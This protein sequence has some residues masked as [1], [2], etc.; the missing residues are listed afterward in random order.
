MARLFPLSLDGGLGVCD[1]FKLARSQRRFRN[2]LIPDALLLEVRIC[3]SSSSFTPGSRTDHFAA[4][5]RAIHQEHRQTVPVDKIHHPL[6][7]TAIPSIKK[8]PKK[9]PKS[10]AKA[11]KLTHHPRHLK[12]PKPPR[13]P[14][15]PKV[16]IAPTGPQTV[17]VTP[18]ATS[19][20]NSFAAAVK[21]ATPGETIV[22]APGTYTQNI[23]VSN[24][25]NITI[26]GAA[27]QSSILAPASGDAIKVV[28]SS[29][30]TIENVWF[31]SQGSQGRGLA[32]VGSS[33]NVQSIKTDGTL[34]DGVVTTGYEGRSA[35][36]NATS[37]QFDAVQTGDGLDL[38]NGSSAIIN[39]STFNG[40][41]TAPGVSQASN[42]L[43][44]SGNATANISNSQFIG[45]TNTGLGAL[46][47][48]QVT[49]QGCTFSS[50]KLGDGAIFFD[51]S[52]AN[53]TGNTF[54]SNGEVF[55]PTTGLNGLEFNGNFTGNA[56]VSGNV[57][58]GNTGDGIF[59]GSAP[60]TIQ[61]TNNV[62]NDNFAGIALYSDGTSIHVNIQSNTLEIPATTPTPF[63]GLFALGS[64]I[65]ATVGGSGSLGNVFNGYGNNV[66][67]YQTQTGGPQNQ[68]LGCPNLN[69]LANTYER[70]GVAL[71]PS[72]AIEPC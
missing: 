67:I 33:V 10:V 25:S 26:V 38:Q 62:F 50:N 31:R 23:V 19:G 71:A 49:A 36:L 59:I 41:G 39:G 44:L 20:P 6:G 21:S 8:A 35:S 28:L 18:G 56:L 57:F 45:N 24:Q 72:E 51:Q 55:G 47:T 1:I 54:A 66:S 65:S 60:N 61:I 70:G 43:I 17:Y 27:N 69:I 48:S 68:N 42:G 15:P 22:L 29:N 4:E 52:T 11:P 37:S 5:L 34:G 2:R 14:K 40:V 13:T 3:P 7:T 9:A 58:Q 64:G 16:P 53:L 46:G 63:V 32:V 30:I 12:P